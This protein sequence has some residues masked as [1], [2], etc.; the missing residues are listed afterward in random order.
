MTEKP[1]C[2]NCGKRGSCMVLRRCLE[3]CARRQRKEV[4]SMVCGAWTLGSEVDLE[5]SEPGKPK[6][7]DNGENTE[8]DHPEEP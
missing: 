8:H 5:L 3:K 2:G 4:Y 7:S 6:D 1:R